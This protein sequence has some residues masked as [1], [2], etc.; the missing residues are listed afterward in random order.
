MNDNYIQMSFGTDCVMRKGGVID[1]KVP[2]EISPKNKSKKKS[3]TRASPNHKRA[4][5]A[6][7][8][9]PIPHYMEKRG[10]YNFEALPPVKPKKKKINVYKKG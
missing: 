3:M 7:I 6:T 2:A 8:R 5:S 9:R 4:K 1:V 10:V